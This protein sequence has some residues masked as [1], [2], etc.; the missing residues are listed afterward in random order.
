MDLER[1][2][3]DMVT[4][5]IE[6]RFHQATSYLPSIVA[7]LDSDDLLQFYGLFK[8]SVIGPCNMAR[9]NIFNM[10]ARSKWAAWHDLGQMSKEAAMQR[11][12]E[13]LDLLDPGWAEAQRI[14]GVNHRRPAWAA[15]ST[16]FSRDEPSNDE[17]TTLVELVKRENID[18]ILAH[19]ASNIT[20]NRTD[21]EK[22]QAINEYDDEGLTALHWAADMGFA[23]VVEI[24]LSHGSDVNS[25]DIESGQT[26][27][28]YAISNH[29]LDVV[30]VL[31]QHGADPT[32]P[33]AEGVTC[34]ALAGNDSNVLPL[35]N[36]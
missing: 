17:Q 33:D 19:F 5:D 31:M 25:K 32:I 20:I 21:E 30:Q 1:A 35:L 8:Q 18:G 12:V 34:I 4:T 24:L 28:H 7:A 10:Q 22:T 26:P 13:K 36:N 11:Y 16:L 6:R 14:S 2:L 23:R 9:P 27:L 3:E 29:N 15:V